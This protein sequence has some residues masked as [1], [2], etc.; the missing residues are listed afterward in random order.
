MRFFILLVCLLVSV[1]VQAGDSDVKKK[2]MRSRS[3]DYK[4]LSLYC[5]QSIYQYKKHF[6]AVSKVLNKTDA[7]ERAQEMEILKKMA[8]YW[9]EQA[10]LRYG[11]VKGA[12]DNSPEVSVLYINRMKRAVEDTPA[13][14]PENARYS[15]VYLEARQCYLIYLQS[16]LAQ[17]DYTLASKNY[18]LMLMDI[19]QHKPAVNIWDAVPSEIPK[20]TMSTNPDAPKLDIILASA[21]PPCRKSLKANHERLK[22]LVREGKIT[23]SV[24]DYPT[25][26]T[27]LFRNVAELNQ[28]I[29]RKK[30]AEAFLDSTA[31]LADVIYAVS[32]VESDEFSSNHIVKYGDMILKRLEKN[33]GVALSECG[34]QEFRDKLWG[35]YQK[36]AIELAKVYPDEDRVPK[37][38]WRGL[39]YVG[40]FSK[41]P[42]LP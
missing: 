16:I 40:D 28:C 25:V 3:V 34:N 42:D 21:C 27:D 23:L 4:E 10:V 12:D 14:T 24:F 35:Q 9:H 11:G 7:D 20:I 15:S 5:T 8:V 13:M 41:I 1:Q 32:G 30:G 17:K 2:F 36:A 39:S 18:T 6:Q 38:F 37:Y 31:S 26:R 19:R 29:Y 33:A 22:T